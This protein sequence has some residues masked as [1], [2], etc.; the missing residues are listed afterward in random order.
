[1]IYQKTDSDLV[2][3][4]FVKCIF[5]VSPMLLSI[6]TCDQ[7]HKTTHSLK[8]AEAHSSP[9]GVSTLQYQVCDLFWF[10]ARYLWLVTI[11]YLFKPIC[12]LV[13]RCKTDALQNEYSPIDF[14]P[15]SIFC[16]L[17]KHYLLHFRK[18]KR[19]QKSQTWHFLLFFMGTACRHWSN[20]ITWK[21]SYK[22]G[23]FQSIWHL[24]RVYPRTIPAV[25]ILASVRKENVFALKLCLGSAIVQAQGKRWSV[26]M[27]HGFTH[28]VSDIRLCQ[29]DTVFIF[30][31]QTDGI[32]TFAF[33]L[34]VKLLCCACSYQYLS[35]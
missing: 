18:H 1:M 6:P 4:G 29:K 14:T 21:D 13:K 16:S 23:E 27:C 17:V 8:G 34:S 7:C 28:S 2:L 12:H 22:K 5:L 15:H 11:L 31:W 3:W 35:H 26:L 32:S 33:C 25:Y 9:M 30:I 10:S 19:T 24:W 20:R